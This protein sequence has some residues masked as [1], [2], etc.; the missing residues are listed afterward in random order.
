VVK[1]RRAAG[2]AALSGLIIFFCLTPLRNNEFHL[3]NN[4][5]LDY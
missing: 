1:K 4:H 3:D 2:G 5:F